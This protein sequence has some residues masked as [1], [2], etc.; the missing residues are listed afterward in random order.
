M[1]CFLITEYAVDS[2]WG[3][4]CQLS[5]NF[6]IK[7]IPEHIHERNDCADLR[8]AEHLKSCVKR[9]TTICASVNIIHNSK[10]Y[11]H[12]EKLN[13]SSPNPYENSSTIQMVSK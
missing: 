2:K 6:F 13:F 12:Q 11:Y 3:I 10:K 9:W 4:S 8:K 7:V 5:S 1:D